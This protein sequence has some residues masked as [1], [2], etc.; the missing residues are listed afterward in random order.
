MSLITIVLEVVKEI[1]HELLDGFRG[2]KY[3]AFLNAITR[4]DSFYLSTTVISIAKQSPI[5]LLEL[6]FCLV[7]GILALEWENLYLVTVSNALH[8]LLLLGS[9]EVD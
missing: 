4:E 9:A 6:L 5:F 3:F 8:E 7:N 2:F 1:E